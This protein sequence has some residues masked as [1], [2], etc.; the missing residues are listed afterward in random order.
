MK[1]LG[2]LLAFMMI[3]SSIYASD[4]TQDHTFINGETLTHTLLN[5]EFGLIATST[6][7]K[8]EKT[9]YTS[10]GSLIFSGVA[11]DITTAANE[12]LS[13]TANN[14]ANLT[15]TGAVNG[16]CTITPNGS[17][18]ITLPVT[19][20][21]VAVTTTTGKL[22]YNGVEVATTGLGNAKNAIINAD[23]DIWQRG[24][25]FAAIANN[26]TSADRFRYSKDTTGAIHTITRDT[27][28]PTTA[29]AG[30]KINYSFKVDCTTADG[31]MAAGDT[32][33]LTYPM[34]GYDFKRFVGQSGTLSFWVKAHKTGIHCVSFQS[35]GQD[36][37]YVAE[38]T[39]S[40]AD[41]WEYKTVTLTFDYAG[42]TWD[43]INGIGLR[44]N[45]ALMEGATYQTVAGAWQNGNYFATANQVNACDSTDNNFWLSHVQFEVGSNATSFEQRP[46]QEELAL[47]QRYY[48]IMGGVSDTIDFNAYQIAGAAF[49]LPIFFRVSKRVAPTVTKNGTWI[50]GNCSQPTANSPSTECF[51]ISTTITASASFQT[52][53]DSADDTITASAEL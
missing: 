5:T 31:A 41:T 35:S 53:T 22:L 40:V 50:V 13:L 30:A 37:S 28:V 2:L 44:I 38:Y 34:E 39:V 52:Y 10:T 49:Q 17:G 46:I 21:N 24:T 7:T 12:G 25:S 33:N 27:D 15:L 36:R 11:T 20:G 29:Q 8:A 43:Y 16:G 4:Y 18:S 45:W 42:G 51:R 47:C 9:G 32:L 19:T 48:E 1:R 6:A 26:A 3:C 23:F 14:G